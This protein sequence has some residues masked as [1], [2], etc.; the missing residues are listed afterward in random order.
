MPSDHT[1]SIFVRAGAEGSGQPQK[2]LVRIRP[3]RSINLL[4]QKK[5]E[6]N[7]VHLFCS[8]DSRAAQWSAVRSELCE[9]MDGFVMVNEALQLCRPPSGWSNITIPDKQTLITDAGKLAYLDGLL[10]R[11]KS[12]NHRVLIYSQMT[13]VIDLL[14]VCDTILFP[15]LN[16]L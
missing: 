1:S 15:S 5:N 8:V 3:I 11:L 12:Q 13:R 9:N 14:E 6:A 10:S 2:V 16:K 7:F 4:L